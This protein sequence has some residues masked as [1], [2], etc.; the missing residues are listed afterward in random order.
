VSVTLHFRSKKGGRKKDYV[1]A[2]NFV[3][4]LI[5][6]AFTLPIGVAIVQTLFW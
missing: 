2:E 5:A 4:S 3:E 6:L 1:R